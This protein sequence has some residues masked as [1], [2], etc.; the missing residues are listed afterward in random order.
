[1]AYHNFLKMIFWISD[2]NLYILELKKVSRVCNFKLNFKIKENSPLI[3]FQ[4]LSSDILL[5][6]KK[7]KGTHISLD[8]RNSVK[9][10][11]L[12][13][14]EQ[15]PH[16]W[17]ENMISLHITLGKSGWNH[18]VG[19]VRTLGWHT[20]YLNHLI[21]SFSSILFDVMQ[22]TNPSQVQTNILELKVGFYQLKQINCFIQARKESKFG[23]QLSNLDDPNNRVIATS[24]FHTVLYEQS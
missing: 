11:Q 15:K 12:P 6:S 14:R 5:L 10:D 24:L 4:H 3:W 17:N 9:S 22:K 16:G 20:L 2:S 19:L 1:M 18:L 8:G 13:L 7:P 21:F 23:P